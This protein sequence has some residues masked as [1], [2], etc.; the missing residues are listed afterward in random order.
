MRSSALVAIAF[1][2]VIFLLVVIPEPRLAQRRQ[3]T[4]LEFV[5]MFLFLLGI[6]ISL[7]ALCVRVEQALV[8]E[9]PVACWGRA[10]TEVC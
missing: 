8:A 3:P 6:P 5:T 10:D 4:E 7:F 9:S 1:Y 2:V